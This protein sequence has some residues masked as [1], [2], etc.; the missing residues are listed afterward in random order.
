LT[1]VYVIAHLRE[2]VRA[3]GEHDG[4]DKQRQSCFG[5]HSCL[6]RA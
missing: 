2:T 5:F 3:C 4:H 1:G 6:S